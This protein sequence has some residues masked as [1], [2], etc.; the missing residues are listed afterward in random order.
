M[1]CAINLTNNNSYNKNLKYEKVYFP[2]Y[3]NFL[4]LQNM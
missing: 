1:D 2:E 3:N 4:L